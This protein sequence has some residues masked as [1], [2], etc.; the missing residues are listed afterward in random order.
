M[1]NKRLMVLRYVMEEFNNAISMLAY[2]FQNRPDKEWTVADLNDT[3]KNRFKLNTAIGQLTKTH[4]ELNTVN[5]PGDN[6]MFRITSMLIPQDKARRTKG[7]SKGLI[8]DA[9]RLLHASIAEVGQFNNLPKNNP[10]GRARIGPNVSLE[11]D[12]TIR[13]RPERMEL[14]DRTQKRLMR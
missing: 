10:D 12:G 2:D 7:H 6:K 5:Y 9:S 14:I 4:G 3:L 1:Y 8:S 11:V 13:R